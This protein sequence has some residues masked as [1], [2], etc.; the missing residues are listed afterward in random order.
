ML[1]R[2][3]ITCSLSASMEGRPPRVGV[4]SAYQQAIRHG[5]G[6]PLL[7]PP[8]LDSEARAALLLTIDGL[9]LPGG[10][11]V[12]PL[13]Y[14]EERHPT[15]VVNP[16][17][18]DLELPLAREAIE[19][20]LPVLAI[21]RGM[22]VVNVACGGSLWQDLPS[23]RCGDIAH[24]WTGPDRDHIAHTLRLDPESWLA[25]TLGTT[26]VPVNT[27]HHQAVKV[28]GH[29]LRVTGSASDDL[30]EAFESD[31]AAR[32]IVGVQCHPE[33]LVET[34]EVWERL[35]RGF[36]HV[37]SQAKHSGHT[38]TARSQTGLSAPADTK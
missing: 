4:N 10:V 20:H 38:A 30:P 2:I 25:R 14:G 32:F 22:Q 11:D 28:V 6:L 3:G 37:A 18:D 23:Q 24:Q 26:D 5:G 12:D 29:G 36:V 35:F 16:T 19:A 15:T 17:L 33:E 9:L 31:D 27:F 34:T 7:I 8:G 21:C 1:P 13:H